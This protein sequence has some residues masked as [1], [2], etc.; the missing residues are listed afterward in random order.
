VVD[1]HR[2][3]VEI[4]MYGRFHGREAYLKPRDAGVRMLCLDEYVN[5]HFE[6]LSH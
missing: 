6:T 2:C 3:L 1:L 4:D 5:S